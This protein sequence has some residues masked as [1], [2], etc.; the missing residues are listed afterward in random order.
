VILPSYGGCEAGLVFKS[1]H[2]CIRGETDEFLVQLSLPSLFQ[3]PQLSTKPF[4]ASVG[5]SSGRSLWA[6]Y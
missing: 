6:E 4:G 1:M 3:Y 2:L 5:K